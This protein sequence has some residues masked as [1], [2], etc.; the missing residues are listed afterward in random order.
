MPNLDWNVNY[1]IV[2]YIRSY[3]VI[4]NDEGYG[5]LQKPSHPQKT[6]RILH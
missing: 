3:G 2:S 4:I 5:Q 6:V 1:Y